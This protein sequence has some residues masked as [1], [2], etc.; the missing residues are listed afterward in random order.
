LNDRRVKQP[1]GKLA[2]GTSAI[3]SHS[4]VFPNHEW[5]NRIA[6]ELLSDS[7]REEWSSR[8]TKDCYKRWQNEGSRPRVNDDEGPL[9]RVQTSFPRNIDVFQSKWI[10]TFEELGHATRSTG[11]TESSVGAVTVTNAV[12]SSISERSHAATVF[13]EPALKRRNVTLKTGVK[14]DKIAFDEASTVDGMLN[15]RSVRESGLSS[16]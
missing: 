14:V 5:H 9:E 2:G 3:N 4:V 6:G 13:L 8:G 11:F 7:R 15:A 10:E 1:R 12:D 16:D